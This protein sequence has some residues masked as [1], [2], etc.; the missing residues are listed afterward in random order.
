MDNISRVRSALLVALLALV[1]LQLP[2]TPPLVL[3]ED[4]WGIELVL[5][6]YYPVVEQGGAIQVEV[7]VYHLSLIHI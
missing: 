6:N 3:A 4:E 5:S 2:I 1:L 7:T